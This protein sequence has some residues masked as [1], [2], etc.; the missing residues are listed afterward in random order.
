[1]HYHLWKSAWRDGQP[2]IAV[3]R[4]QRIFATRQAAQ[5]YKKRLGY[6]G[7]SDAA[8][9]FVRACVGSSEEC[10]NLHERPGQ[11]QRGD[12]NSDS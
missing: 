5:K 12:G 11:D 8:F 10:G 3:F 6:R 7:Y 2:A 9:G 4:E 1:M